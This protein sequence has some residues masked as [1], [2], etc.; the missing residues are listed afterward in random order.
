MAT[1]KYTGIEFTPRKDQP[2]WTTTH[3]AIK[4]AYAAMI[5][6]HSG[7]YQHIYMSAADR[8]LDAAIPFSL[9][10]LPRIMA[11]AERAG[12][13]LEDETRAYFREEPRQ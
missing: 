2:K 3:P 8:A 13:Q 11:E 10:D 12:E 9:S 6:R 4:D 5:E 1:C 7:G